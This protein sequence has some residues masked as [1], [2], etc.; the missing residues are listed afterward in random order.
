MELCYFSEDL[1]FLF[2][3]FLM[4]ACMSIKKL[5]QYLINQLKAWEIVERPASIVK[6]LLENAL[7]A[8]ATD[9]VVEIGQWGK[10]MIRVQDNGTGMSQD[11]LQMS[12]ERYATSKID[13]ESDLQMIDSYGFRWEALASVS[14]VSVFRMQT[15]EKDT[16]ANIGY[17]LYHSEWRYTVKEIPFAREH[18]TTVFVQDVF[19][20]IPAREKFLKSDNTEWKYIKELFLQYAL[21]HPDKQWSLMHNGKQIFLFAPVKSLMQRILDITKKDREKNLKEIA[22]QDQQLHVYGVVWDATLHFATGQYFWIFVNGR[23]VQDKVLKKAI[24]QAYQRQIVPGSYPFVC[25]FVEIDPKLVDVN[26]HPRKTEVKFLDPGSMF[27]RINES[28]AQAIW[29]TKV[30]YASFRQADIQWWSWSGGRH[31]WKKSGMTMQQVDVLK[32]VWEIRKESWMFGAQDLDRVWLRSDVHNITQF[33]AWDEAYALVGQL[34]QSYILLESPDALV[35]IDQHALAERIAFEQMKQK[36]STEGFQS[37]VLLSPLSLDAPKDVDLE[38]KLE[39]LQQIWF[40]VAELGQGKI[41]IYAIP[42]VFHEWKVDIELIINRV[43]WADPTSDWLSLFSLMIDEMVGM[44]ACKASIKAGQKLSNQEMKQL[45]EDGF[46]HISGMFVCQHG[47]P[48]AVRIQKGNVD[49]LF[50][51]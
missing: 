39:M 42:R 31:R 26:V 4:L 29:D 12:I 28:V 47:R 51:R 8:W 30:N 38:K 5:P 22:Y 27:T 13:E 50:D 48:S 3:F 10:K 36:I 34:R 17:E 2:F 6:E 9:L 33:V 15:R 20:A 23:P 7:D 14:E 32:Q 11:D 35:Y 37:E 41:V 46:K 25:L 21:V 1:L 18:G 44:K 16:Q 49:G 43:W 19:H 24:M 45:V 40:D